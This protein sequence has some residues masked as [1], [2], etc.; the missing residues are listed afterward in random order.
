MAQT[1]SLDRSCARLGA[2]LFTRA[3]QQRRGPGEP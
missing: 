3:A 2:M 1:F